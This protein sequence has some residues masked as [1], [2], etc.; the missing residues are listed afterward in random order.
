MVDLHSQNGR[1][2]DQVKDNKRASTVNLQTGPSTNDG[3]VAVSNIEAPQKANLPLRTITREDARNPQKY[4][5]A[6]AAAEQAGSSLT[7]LSDNSDATTRNT[8]QAE[9][10]NSRVFTFDDTHT[11]T[12][13]LRADMQTGNG[14][15]GRRMQAE[16]E[17]FVIKT[18]RTT[19]DLPEHAQ[20]MFKSK[21]KAANA[22]S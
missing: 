9:V 11:M 13:W 19:D 3:L 4:R 6:K 12:R 17:G 22:K 15:V 10:M 18:F 1:L 7:I 16:K 20:V 14:I 21:E 2:L 8:G 5:E